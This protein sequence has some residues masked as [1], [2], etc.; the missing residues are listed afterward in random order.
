M[1]VENRKTT[2]LEKIRRYMIGRMTILLLTYLFT[3]IDDDKF[4]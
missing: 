4:S 3:R 2:V 1:Y